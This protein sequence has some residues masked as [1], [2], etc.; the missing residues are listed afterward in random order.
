MAFSP[1]FESQ[2]I[3]EFA[4]IVR[5]GTS[6]AVY[7]AWIQRIRDACSQ[8]AD[9]NIQKEAQER[10]TRIC[11]YGFIQIED[12]EGSRTGIAEEL[13]ELANFVNQI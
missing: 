13:E 4:A 10:I 11:N 5:R 8:I 6:S 12:P 7:S 1:Q 3:R 2:Y 9:P